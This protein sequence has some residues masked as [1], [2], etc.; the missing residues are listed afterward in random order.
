MSYSIEHII[1]DLS[2]HLKIDI[3]D[4]DIHFFNEGTTESIVFSIS[5]KYLIKIVDDNT[6]KTQ[7]EFLKFYKDVPEFQKIVFY[8]K[9]LKY[10]CFEYI[11]G[12]KISKNSTINSDDILMK[13]CSIVKQYKEYSCD[14]YGYL[15][16]NHK[17]WV[18]FLLD[19]VKYASR[20]S[21]TRF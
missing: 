12:E 1:N 20:T 5:N 11:D 3:E 18:E 13:I 14:N 2:N 10:L 8:N 17:T 4:K 9:H 6:L 21:N 7:M 16:D 15:W 19:E